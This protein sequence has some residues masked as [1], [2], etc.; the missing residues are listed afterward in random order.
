M[1][2]TGSIIYP[3][4]VTI[5][6]HFDSPN[7]IPMSLENW[8][9]WSNSCLIWFMFGAYNFKSSTKYKF[10]MF[11]SRWPLVPIRYYRS[12]L[13][14]NDNGFTHRMNRKIDRLSP[15]KMPRKEWINL[16]SISCSFPSRCMFV[17][18][19]LISSLR[20]FIIFDGTVASSKNL[21]SHSWG[22]LSNAFW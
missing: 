7:F 8:V 13:S 5:Y 6:V 20:A 12:L 3:F 2:S 1:G 18:Q 9:T 4:S 21:I 14:K 15:W 10:V 19:F 16:I 22:T 17:A 11:W